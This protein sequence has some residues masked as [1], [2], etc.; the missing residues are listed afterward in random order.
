MIKSSSCAVIARLRCWLKIYIWIIYISETSKCSKLCFPNYFRISEFCLEKHE[1]TRQRARFSWPCE[2]YET[3]H[4]SSFSFF[5]LFAFCLLLYLG[6][7]FVLTLVG[8]GN[9]LTRESNW[10]ASLAIARK[11]VLMEESSVAFDLFHLLLLVALCS[12]GFRRHLVN[13][14]PIFWARV[15]P[16]LRGTFLW[17][18]RSALFST[19]SM[20]IV[21]SFLRANNLTT[22][23]LSV[24][25]FESSCNTY[26][27]SYS[28][29][30]FE[31]FKR[32]G[33]VD[34]NGCLGFKHCRDHTLEL[35]FFN[36]FSLCF[37]F[38]LVE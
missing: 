27:V 7:C 4:G 34:D 32:S 21:S 25:Q 1:I 38:V 18:T 33:W 2:C 17:W 35:I 16:K 37:W 30:S 10:V 3:R 19:K 31:W 12:F 36:Q 24:P 20:G 5:L 6:F 22:S 28:N 26:F 23:Q 15:G 13:M 29:S 14:Q 9:F 11:V 8:W